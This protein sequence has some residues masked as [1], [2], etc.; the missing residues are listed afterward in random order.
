LR[1]GQ[2]EAVFR[3]KRKSE[4]MFREKEEEWRDV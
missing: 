2:S 4:A 3:E 1:L